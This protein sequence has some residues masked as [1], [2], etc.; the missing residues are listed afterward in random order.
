MFNYHVVE[1]NWGGK[2]LKLETGHLARQ[3]NGAVLVTYGDTQVLC[4]VVAV[5]E[6]KPEQDF[7]PLSVHYQEKFY[8]AGRIPG[9]FFKREGRPTEKEVLTSRL[10]DRPIRPLF[11]ETFQNETQIIATLLSHDL[12]NDPDIAAMI[13][14]SAALAI[15]GIPFLGP[16]GACRVA[17]KNDQFI[18]NPMKSE[19]P[20]TLLDLVVAGTKE[21]VLMVESE[22][23]QLSEETMLDAVVFGHKALQEVVEMI[24]ELKAKVNNPAWEV[25][26]APA[27]AATLKKIID[28]VATEPVK[29]AYQKTKK[30]ERYNDLDAVKKLVAEAVA[31]EASAEMEIPGAK[32][33][34]AKLLDDLKAMIVRGNILSTKKRIDGRGLENIRQID[35]QVGV[36]KKTHGSAVF[37]RGETQ[38]LVIATLGTAQDKQIIDAIDGEFKEEFLLHYNFPP[39]SV[40]EAGRIGSPGRREIGHGKLAWRALRPLL[41]SKE[42]FPYMLRLVSEITESNGSSS[43]A[44]VCGGS[45]AM[46][47]AGVPMKAPCAGIAMGLIKEGTDYAVLSDILGDEDHLGDMDFKV[48]GTKDGVTSLQ[49]DLKI[50]SIT[51][52]IMKIALGQAKEGRLHILGE[53]AKA[54]DHGRQEVSKNAPRLTT[55]TI[56]KEKIREV[57]GTGGKVIREIVEV[58]GAKV[59]IDDEGVITIAANDETKGKAAYDWI[60]GIVAEAEAGKIYHGK[61]A[62]VVDFGVFVNYMGAK[63]GLVH[64]SEMAEHR[65]NHPSDMV[66]EGDMVWVK[67]LGTERGKVSLSMRMV[68]QQSGED[69]NLEPKNKGD[70]GGGGGDRGGRG[71]GGF[72]GRGGGGGRGGDRGGGGGFGGRGGGDRGGGG[73]FGGGRV[74]EFSG[75]DFGGGGDRGG[76]RGGGG[77]F[78]GGGRGGG[79][80]RRRDF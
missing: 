39:F 52:E 9:G 1:K 47:D 24:N 13:G 46:M 11:P 37:T 54:I 61:V 5:K 18:L 67:C 25:P 28:K 10:I 50:T 72:G 53:M 71:G 76:G 31:K 63:D 41:P 19:M 62:S 57:I 36:L 29:A 40:G 3:A 60:Q 7:F 2:T 49:M 38:A 30:Q 34:V 14:S 51:P 56:A 32:Q 17:Y 6:S 26:S 73:G 58:T 22:A 16:I 33:V 20:G 64:V 80:K 77:G 59:D 12:E 70:R 23:H 45:M 35:C 65:V 15:S 4:T 8:A 66:K 75:D 48:A 69:L 68:D 78:G 55:F 44:S 42:D 74:R 27:H 43:M 79:G 21:G